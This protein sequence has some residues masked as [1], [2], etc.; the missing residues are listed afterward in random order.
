[1]NDLIEPKTIAVIG[2]GAIGGITAACLQ[3]SGLDVE[4]VCKHQNT[5]DH[6]NSTGLHIFGIRGDET[7]KVKAV[8]DIS[9]LSGKK[10]LVLLAT[11]AT[12]C[13]EA[14]E[15]LLPFLQD[16][17]QVVSLQ[18]GICE[19]V[20]AEI[21]GENRVIGCVV[22]WSA[23]MLTPGELELTNEGEFI[24]G[25]IDSREPAQLA[26]VQAILQMTMPT[27]VSDS[28][29]ADL[30]SKLV[31]NACMNS[32]CVVT[33]LELSPLLKQKS[34]RKMF[35]GIMREAITVAK[36]AGIQVPPGRLNLTKLLNPP[37]ILGDV[38]RYLFLRLMAIASRKVKLSSMQSIARGRKTEVDFLNGYISELGRKHRVPTPLNDMMVS[39]VKEIENGTRSMSLDNLCSQG[40]LT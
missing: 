27:R 32:P 25:P 33:G 2:A 12:E 9:E 3:K 16:D 17:S 38:K 37:N 26:P 40:N 15:E 35:I 30:Y 8:K 34:G 20:L 10:D 29:M 7:V 19:T 18:N 24:I 36:A 28:I 21:L 1:M 5:T 23:T 11:K 6:V 39:M 4:L 13:L 31:L 14:A 22:G